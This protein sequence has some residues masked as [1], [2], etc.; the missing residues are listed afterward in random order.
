MLAVIVVVVASLIVGR[1]PAVA[2][3][4]CTS[5]PG[6]STYGHWFTGGFQDHGGTMSGTSG[7]IRTYNP[8]VYWD[9]GSTAAWVMGVRPGGLFGDRFAQA[10][11]AKS[12]SDP[13]TH[14]PFNANWFIQYTGAQ[15][16]VFNP[17]WFGAIAPPTT[18]FYQANSPAPDGKWTFQMGP[19]VITD[20]AL[21]WTPTMHQAFGEEWNLTGDQTAGDRN[22]HTT[23][24]TVQWSNFSSWLPSQFGGP[25]NPYQAGTPNPPS[26]PDRGDAGYD[27]L[28]AISGSDFDIWDNRCP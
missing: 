14:D 9:R 15:G 8:F 21:G 16:E 24:R 18:Y 19:T 25:S 27:A 22:T 1:S 5:L 6:S 20:V 10:G 3:S 4:A 12:N 7:F 23:F 17:L 28:S 26:L 13:S 2:D 11:W